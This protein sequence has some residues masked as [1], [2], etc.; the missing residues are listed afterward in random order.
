LF[1]DFATDSL[2]NDLSKVLVY[3]N[4]SADYKL[5]L[6][7]A[8]EIE[9]KYENSAVIQK[10]FRTY[11]Q[12]LVAI[13]KIY[14]KSNS[15]T[16]SLD[17]YKRAMAVLDKKYI[18]DKNINQ[19]NTQLQNL[20]NIYLK[21]GNGFMYLSREDTTLLD[22]AKYYYQKTLNIDSFDKKVLSYQA[23]ASSNMSGIY[24]KDS[25]FSKA[26]EYALKAVEIHNKRDNK[27]SEA[28]AIGN[29]ASIFLEEKNILKQSNFTLK[30]LIKL[31]M[32]HQ[33][34]LYVF[35]NNSITI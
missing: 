11:S 5:A 28:V 2:K 7:K 14:R 22:S 3:Y 29:L 15:Y 10:D 6:E 19:E 18:S 35:E 33:K 16:K 26:E 34:K 8:L 23:S 4:D 1:Q 9:K 25:L 21:V 32:S 31:K 27:I 17:Y 24:M 30:H 13:G 20:S 12:L